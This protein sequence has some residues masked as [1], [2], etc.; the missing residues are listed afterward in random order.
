MKRLRILCFSVLFSFLAGLST[1][2]WSDDT[3][4]YLNQAIELSK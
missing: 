4:L 1:P 2:G 3:D